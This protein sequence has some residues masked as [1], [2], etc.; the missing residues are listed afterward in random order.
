[1]IARVL[2]WLSAAILW[3]WSGL[4]WADES[5][6]PILV[7]VPRMG[8][9]LVFGKDAASAMNSYVEG[10]V[11]RDVFGDVHRNELRAWGREVANNASRAPTLEALRATGRPIIG[12]QLNN[13]HDLVG[14]DEH[15]AETIAKWKAHRMEAATAII[16]AGGVPVFLPPAG[17]AKH[18]EPMVAELDHLLLMGGADVATE[19]QPGVPKDPR[20]H[21]NLKIDLYEQKVLKAALAR[22]L[23]VHAICRGSQLVEVT[24]GGGLVQDIPSSGLTDLNHGS[25]QKQGTP[26]EHSI[27]VDR[28]SVL[29]QDLG[30]KLVVK[31]LHHHHQ[32]S[33]AN[34]IAPGFRAIA[35]AHDG[36][37]EGI[38]SD[39]GRIVGVQVHPESA[40][41]G[42]ALRNAFFGTMVKAATKFMVANRAPVPA[43]PFA[44]ERGK[45]LA[46]HTTVG[47]GTLKETHS[48]WS[49][50][51]RAPQ[52]A[53][54]LGHQVAPRV[55]SARLA[56]A[57]H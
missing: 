1:V 14:D 35:V 34:N 6:R 33:D 46:L 48:I 18:I 22:G 9:M 56:A 42:S 38:E 3:L 53:R 5:A 13:P 30:R 25:G 26:A 50:P 21:T 7:Q 29:G 57:R 47:L 8:P 32:A 17:L 49:T 4:A 40:G 37:V 51:P 2:I 55:N 45:T 15:D 36:I 23:N 44:S 16:Q 43:L 24:F 41:R 20:F 27:R 28:D 12:I 10:L 11:R 39:D 52:V 31:G 19:L 54:S